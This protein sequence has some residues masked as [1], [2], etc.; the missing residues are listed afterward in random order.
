MKMKEMGPTGGAHASCPPHLGSANGQE[1]DIDSLQKCGPNLSLVS[2][3]F[4][5]SKKLSCPKCLINFYI[6]IVVV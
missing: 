4:T 1:H 6:N 5:I 3:S 2:I